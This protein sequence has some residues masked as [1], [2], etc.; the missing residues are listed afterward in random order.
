MPNANEPSHP[1]EPV[2]RDAEAELRR[3]LREACEAEADDVTSD[4][5]AEVRRLEDTLLAAAV[6]AGQTVALRRHIA[7][8]DMQS[9]SATSSERPGPAASAQEGKTHEAP[10]AETVQSRSVG[11]V[12]EF[13]DATG[14][15]WRAWPVV[16][17]SARPGRNTER[18]LGEFHKGWVCFESLDSSAR[19]RLPQQQPRWSELGEHELAV[20]LEQAISAPERRKLPDTSA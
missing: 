6:A 7:G 2:L 15:M 3:R 17:G 18:Y 20:L 19:R 5:V 11:V 8:S 12:R 1:L 14:R 4:S 16:P 10:P 13:R 9:P